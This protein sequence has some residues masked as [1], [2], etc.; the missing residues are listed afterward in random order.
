[1]SSGGDATRDGISLPTRLFQVLLL[2]Q[3]LFMLLLLVIMCGI[4][5]FLN[6]HFLSIHNFREITVQ[7]GVIAMLAVGQTF[8][9]LS[10]GIDLG[11]GS[12]VALASVT[13]AMAME[14]SGS[15]AVSFPVGILVGALCGAANGFMVGG[16]GIPPFVATFGM[17]C[18]A[19]G[20]ALIVTHGMPQYIV[21]PGYDIIGQARTMGIPNST[22]LVI[23]LYV[24]CYLIL[25]RTRRGR[26]T[27]AIGSNQDATFLSGINI[28][29]QLIWIYMVSGITAGIAGITELSRI[30]SGQPGAGSG[31][32][33][34]AIAAVV[35]GGTSMSGG[36]GSLWGS[37]VGALFITTLRNGLN[38]M[39]INAHWQQ[40]AVGFIVVLAVYADRI[41]NNMRK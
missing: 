22:L 24:V 21:S 37:L 41:R 33:L 25:I 6:Q 11:M 16:L 35:V 30:G 39:N 12:V 29:W 36:M 14:A 34:D 5:A 31:Y 10:A 38:V 40:V 9:I 19:R 32:E 15:T 27:Y 20:L 7:A 17:L 18:I 26:Y 28:P 1:M 23:A 8:V 2:N 13:T 3:S 4:I